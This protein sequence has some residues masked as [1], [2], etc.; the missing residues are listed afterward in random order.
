MELSAHL[1]VSSLVVPFLVATQEI[2]CG[3][4]VASHMVGYNALELQQVNVALPTLEDPF[5][6]TN[7][8]GEIRQGFHM[9]LIAYH[10]L[11]CCYII[12][13]PGDHS[14]LSLC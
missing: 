13:C 9:L 4:Y 5:I 10:T 12:S 8:L 7:Y 11:Q 3:T 14:L 1:P 6:H 2:L